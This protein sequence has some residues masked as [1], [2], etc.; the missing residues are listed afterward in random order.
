MRFS[1]LTIT[2]TAF[3]V[4]QVSH[5][6]VVD[7]FTTTAD[8]IAKDNGPIERFNPK[9]CWWLNGR[10]HCDGDASGVAKD[11]GPVK[12]FNSKN[13]WWLNGRYHCDGDASGSAPAQPNK[14]KIAKGPV[15]KFNPKNCWWLNGRYHCDGDASGSAVVTVMASARHGAPKLVKSKK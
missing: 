14:D 4:L 15:E 11:D 3:T 1:A 8:K 12:K 2:A 10:Y 7:P 13:C 5:A 9:N 6:Q